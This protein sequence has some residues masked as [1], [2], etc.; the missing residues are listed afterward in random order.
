MQAAM[1]AFSLAATIFISTLADAYEIAF[2]PYFLGLHYGAD[3]TPPILWS[4]YP[5]FRCNAVSFDGF[6]PNNQFTQNVLVRTALDGAGPPKAIMFYE[7]D[8]GDSDPCGADKQEL[9]GV[10]YPDKP[11]QQI[12]FTESRGTITHWMELNEQS[13]Q[14]ETIR[15]NGLLPGDVLHWNWRVNAWEHDSDA[16]T[17]EAFDADIAYHDVENYDTSSPSPAAFL[18]DTESES[19]SPEINTSEAVLASFDSLWPPPQEVPDAEVFAP[20]YRDYRN[21]RLQEASEYRSIPRSFLTIYS[22][23]QLRRMGYVVDMKLE[24]QRNAALDMEQK[25]RKDAEVFYEALRTNQFPAGNQFLE[26]LIYGWAPAGNWQPN[27]TLQGP[28]ETEMERI[29]DGS[30]PNGQVDYDADRSEAVTDNSPGPGGFSP[31]GV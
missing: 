6:P 14:W 30:S 1:K 12:L 7:S 28:S 15:E 26:D 19:N 29:E 20:K 22:Y 9:L 2:F 5:R 3:P 11:S 16:I 23:D 27:G 10:F 31:A 4:V 24:A 25:R 18:E 13:P 17:N 21:L 8:P